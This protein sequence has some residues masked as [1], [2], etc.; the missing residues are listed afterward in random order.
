MQWPFLFLN[1]FQYEMQRAVCW[2]ISWAKLLCLKL[3]ARRALMHKGEAPMYTRMCI[4]LGGALMNKLD[5]FNI[6]LVVLVIIFMFLIILFY[7]HI[8]AYLSTSDISDNFYPTFVKM[9]DSD[10]NQ[11]VTNVFFER[12]K[13]LCA[14][15]KYF[16]VFTC[17]R[18]PYKTI[19][20]S[21]LTLRP[22]I[23]ELLFRSKKTLVGTP[24]AVCPPTNSVNTKQTTKANRLEQIALSHST[25]ATE[26][27]EKWYQWLAGLIDGDGSLLVSKA[28][29][30]SLEITVDSKDEAVL[31]KVKQAYGGSIK[32]RAGLNAVRYRLH[33]TPAMKKL[34]HHINGYIRHPAR[35][36]Q[37][38]KVC[39]VLDIPLKQPDTLNQ[40]HGWFAG[41]FDSDGT[42]TI[43]PTFQ[44]SIR[45]CSKFK[46]VVTPFHKVF[47]GS[48][49]YDKSQNGYWIWSVQSKGDVTRLIEYYKQF[50][51]QRSRRTRFFLV[52]HI[53]ELLM[54]KAH[55]MPKH[56]VLNKKWRSVLENWKNA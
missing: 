17:I 43:N 23:K 4:H 53:Y 22:T 16:D 33:N 13:L 20:L 52:P 27:D 51:V 32:P 50:P 39:N 28:G 10:L 29:Y 15:I 38:I 55:H 19:C 49:Y 24:E 12:V 2:N 37:L 6:K 35:F 36:Q 45:V 1:S 5:L 56:S 40:T 9:T 3:T 34:I 48:L 18:M 47:G 26:Y 14:S 44:V 31:Y 46:E 11:Q 7:N 42:I 25:F 41:M 54:L 30:S 21:H 8:P